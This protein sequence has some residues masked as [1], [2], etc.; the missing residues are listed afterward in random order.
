MFF[1]NDSS[2]KVLE[3]LNSDLNGLNTREVIKRRERS[4]FN[5]LKEK[6]K[7]SV[8]KLF[9]ENFK[10]PLVIIL[11]VAAGIQIATGHF[12]D[13]FIILIVLIL[14]S[15]LN[16]V[17]TKKAEGSLE[18]LRKLSAPMAKVLRDGQKVSIPAREIV[19]GDIVLL[20]AGDYIPADGRI[21]EAETLRVLESSLTGESEPV[22]KVTETL[23]GELPLGDRK[24]M[25]FSGSLA[26]YGRGKFVVT[27]TGM[28][29]E[30]GKIAVLLE[31]ADE[32]LTPLQENLERFT[33]KLGT[34]ILLLSV[35]IFAV[36]I[37]K[38]IFF[39]HERNIGNMILEAFMFSVAVAVAAIPEAL[40]SIVT[41]V[42]SV[43]TNVM[44]K[45]GVIIRKLPAVETLGSTG[46]ICTDKTGTLTQN[47]MTVVGSYL[48]GVETPVFNEKNCDGKAETHEDKFLAANLLVNDA[49][50]TEEGV[51]IGDPTELALLNFL[52]KHKL[53]IKKIKEQFIRIG[54][55]PFDSDR[56]IMST[57]N[58]VDGKKILFSKGAPD[59]IFKRCSYVL[60]ENKVVSMDEK[61]LKSYEEKNEEFSENALRVLALAYREMELGD[62]K[63]GFEDE[64]DY[65]L[66][67]LVA[68]ID[69]PREEVFHA[70][71]EAESAGIKTV[72]I[73][74]DHK[75][76][77][78]AI[79]REIGIMKKNDMA[80]TGQELDKLTDEE[81]LEKLEKI[82]V[83]A[84]VSPENK[85]RIVK[86]W[87]KRQ[88]ITAMTGDGVND[89]PALKQ[90][91]IGVAM[92]TGTDVAK[93]AGAMIL[94]DDN[95]ASI[96]NAI[97]IG[98]TVYKNI[99]KSIVYLF[100]G[101]L[102]AILAILFAL[103]AGWSA[104]FTAL[105]LLF[106][107][108]ANDSL[109]A[110]ALGLEPSDI[111]V[112]DEKPRDPKEPLFTKKN[113][114][115]IFFRGSIIAGA[116]VVAQYLGGKND[117]LGISMAFTTLLFCRT[118]Q[119][120]P[121][122]DEKRSIVKL[123]IFKNI[124]T[125]IAVGVCFGLYFLVQLPAFRSYFSIA[126]DFG[127]KQFSICLGLAFAST[128][129]MEL[130]KIFSKKH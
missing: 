123:G 91:D 127:W 4:G 56:K 32:N 119:T 45:K 61:A 13:S 102:G 126:E 42:L 5:E 48:Y 71:E 12:I 122:R 15:I 21:T 75:T 63:I 88:K 17:Q 68:M 10:D 59:V 116:T 108:L 86:A 121:A 94:T 82:S 54:E 43:G 70:I 110:I 76:T 55:L 28:E 115:T 125:V 36:L 104:P 84:R 22:E 1:Y 117:L 109:P 72:M 128:I 80:L 83:Y 87:Q 81:L 114:K 101:N 64:K 79:A 39:A 103:F 44:A 9:L 49:A 62:E 35:L 73:T 33:K 98:R 60:Q 14:N 26:V 53:D 25:V 112:M 130:E 69:P 66:L 16:V 65:V 92:G 41:I 23:C 24:N 50:V 11:L 124:Y 129:I 120:F 7:A 18:A 74:G 51:G 37:I 52:V 27:R 57:L 58:V 6:E 100:S 113:Y 95:F 90:A 85:I 47:R 77:A 2:E 30:I 67:G 78:Q 29:T 97:E 20:D 31:E 3:K 106:I 105:Q 118:L 111:A 46:V 96:V 34:G 107:N 40:S 38:G 8:L 89:A 99:K 93:D 19:P